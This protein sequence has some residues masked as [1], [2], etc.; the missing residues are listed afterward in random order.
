MIFSLSFLA[1]SIIFT[2]VAHVLLKKGSL[3]HSEGAFLDAY[4]NIYTMF[5]Y[6]IFFLSTIFTVY[7]LQ[8]LDLKVVY[9]VSALSIPLVVIFSS[10]YLSES[11]RKKAAVSVFLITLGVFVFN[12]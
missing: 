3:L 10:I 8:G 2:A 1:I 7:A 4:L 6:F 9:A 12:I 5:G 11:I